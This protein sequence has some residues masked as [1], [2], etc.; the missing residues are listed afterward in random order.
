MSDAGPQETGQ[1]DLL[2]APTIKGQRSFRSERLLLMNPLFPLGSK[3]LH[4][5]R[6]K[7][8]S[9]EGVNLYIRQSPGE[10]GLATQFDFDLLAYII[11]LIVKAKNEGKPVTPR[12]RFAIHDCL[13]FVNRP[14]SGRSYELF[15]LSMKRLL[16]TTTFTNLESS[17]ARFDAGFNWLQSF[18]TGRRTTAAG[19]EVMTYAEVVLCDWL[20]EAIL[21]DDVL[22]LDREYFDL[23]KGLDRKVFQLARAH[24]GAKSCWPIGVERLQLKTGYEGK[25]DRFL[26]DLKG[27]VRRQPFSEW[28]VILSHDGREM[29]NYLIDPDTISGRKNVYLWVVRRQLKLKAAHHLPIDRKR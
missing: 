1:L 28:F 19:R 27:I 12:V 6:E 29:P 9:E 10:F 14:T 16:T 22:A 20:F 13:K 5:A 23:T 15:L 21:S 2:D 25:K 7:R 11:T 3:P 17:G 24:L 18:K 26:F 8:W 4:R